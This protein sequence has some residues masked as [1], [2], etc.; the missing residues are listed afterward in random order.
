MAR[1][2]STTPVGL[3]RPW[4]AKRATRNA[5]ESLN[6][7]VTHGRLE[8]RRNFFSERV[9]ESWNRIPATLNTEKLRTPPMQPAAVRADLWR[10]ESEA[11]PDLTFPERPYL[12]HGG[13]HTSKQRTCGR[14]EMRARSSRIGRSL[15]GPT[16]AL[17]GLHTAQVNK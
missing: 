13:L 14:G 3:R 17:G 2:N 1:A 10:D 4:M 12:G 7:K 11:I 16:W 9:I 6:L 15:R 5:A 8:L